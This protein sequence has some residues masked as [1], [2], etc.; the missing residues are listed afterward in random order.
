MFIAI[1]A[2][3]QQIHHPLHNIG[4]Y[5]SSLTSPIRTKVRI[6]SY[7]KGVRL[8]GSTTRVERQRVNRTLIWIIYTIQF[9]EKLTA[10]EVELE[11]C[12]F[13]LVLGLYK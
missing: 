4:S 9:M 6:R 8:T 10:K 11:A 13:A 7:H 1:G 5:D 2:P 12:V 3:L